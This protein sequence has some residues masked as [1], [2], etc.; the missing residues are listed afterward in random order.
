MSRM[1]LFLADAGVPML[2][3]AFP[4]AFYLLI[5]VVALETWIARTVPQISLQRRFL[6]V[7]GANVFSTAVGWPIAW[8]IMVLLQIY[9]IPGGSGGYGLDTP[10]HKIASVTLQAAWLIP[11]ERDLYWMVPTAAIVLLVPAF[12]IT[13]P[14]ERLVLRY[15]WRQTAVSER[16]RFVWVANVAS[17]ALLVIAGLIWLCYSVTHYGKST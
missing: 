1:P 14:S 6:G 9:V 5:P 8:Y 15:I 3:V 7:L 11:Y 17:Y 10:L 13:I 4:F 16:R 2:F 12:L